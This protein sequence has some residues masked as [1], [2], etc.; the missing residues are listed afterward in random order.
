[1][2]ELAMKPEDITSLCTA[3]QEAL[4]KRDRQTRFKWRGKTYIAT[5]TSF[6]I[7]VDDAQGNPVCC[8][9]M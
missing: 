3:A 5:R 8:R 4:D 2:G 9:W 6:R 7:L 1:M